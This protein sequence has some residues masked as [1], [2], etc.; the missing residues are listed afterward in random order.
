M[1]TEVILPLYCKVTEISEGSLCITV[2]AETPAALREL[3]D[4]Y[5]DGTLQSRLQ[6][7]LVTEEIKELAGGEDIEVTVY[8]YE[9]EYKEAYFDLLLQNEGRVAAIDTK[10]EVSV[11][12]PSVIVWLES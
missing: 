8:I 10:R 4:I 7:F 12:K 3:W 2:Q 1:I 9:Q 5:K 6:E 11:V